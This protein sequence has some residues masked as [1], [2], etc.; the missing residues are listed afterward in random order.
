MIDSPLNDWIS[1][2][3]TRSS[4]HLFWGD[5]SIQTI[6]GATVGAPSRLHVLHLGSVPL[7]RFRSHRCCHCGD[8]HHHL[9]RGSNPAEDVSQ[10]WQALGPLSA[11]ASVCT[12]RLSDMPKVTQFYLAELGFKPNTFGFK[13]N[14]PTITWSNGN[15]KVKRCFKEIL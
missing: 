8:C 1:H 7:H 14:T 11:P 4:T 9:H 3:G 13:E 10:V 6:A 15:N 5:T 12:G 2:L